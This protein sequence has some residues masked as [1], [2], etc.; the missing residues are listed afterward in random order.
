[1][2]IR[3]APTRLMKELGDGRDY[4]YAHNYSNAYAP[5]HYLPDQLKGNYYYFPQDRGYEKN[6][7]QRLDH[8][9][10]LLAKT[11]PAKK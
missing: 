5:Q 7:K 11:K 3:N 6:I 1:M 4:K 8:W 9:R 2:H 10:S